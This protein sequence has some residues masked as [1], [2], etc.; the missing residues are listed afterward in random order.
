MDNYN[1][2]SFQIRKYKIESTK[3]KHKI[4]IQIRKY[5]IEAQKN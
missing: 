4:E 5:K 3:S 1:S 2:M